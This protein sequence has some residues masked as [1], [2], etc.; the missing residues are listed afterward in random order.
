MTCPRGRVPATATS[1]SAGEAGNDDVEERGD[2]SDDGS[3]NTGDT[4]D[5]CHE[6]SSNG[7]EERFDLPIISFCW[8][9]LHFSEAG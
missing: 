7:L 5:D 8:L 1:L 4:V 2:G 6:T 3:E 9:F